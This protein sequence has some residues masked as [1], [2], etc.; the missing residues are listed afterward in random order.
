M[1]TTETDESGSVRTQ[2][3]PTQSEGF[4]RL[5]NG[6]EAV[7]SERI[8]ELWSSQY[9]TIFALGAGGACMLPCFSAEA[10]FVPILFASC[11]ST[12]QNICVPLLF[13][14]ARRQLGSCRRWRVQQW[15]P[16][17]LQRHIAQI[18]SLLNA[19][20]LG[21]MHFSL[22]RTLSE[23]RPARVPCFAESFHNH[24]AGVGAYGSA[25]ALAVLSQQCQHILSL[26]S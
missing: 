8:M 23:A 26:S 5:P 25:E 11:L 18:S 20:L 9:Q 3:T 14:T 2:S 7:D 24:L 13:A 4:F 16:S 1:T 10:R 6:D 15:H 21:R 22:L 12:R 19:L 17:W